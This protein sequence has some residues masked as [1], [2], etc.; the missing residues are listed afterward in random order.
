MI[1]DRVHPLKM[2][3]V[4]VAVS[5]GFRCW[6]RDLSPCCIHKHI[7]SL[8]VAFFLQTQL[9]LDPGGVLSNAVHQLLTL[10]RHVRLMAK[11]ELEGW[12]DVGV[13]QT[14]SMTARAVL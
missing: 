8:S 14:L 12:R 6:L 9:F 3:H 5:T 10:I 13:R 11:L 1:C 4:D 2:G 7:L